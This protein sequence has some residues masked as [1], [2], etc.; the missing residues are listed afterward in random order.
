M[1]RGENKELVKIHGRLHEGQATM[2]NI[3][4]LP[5]QSVI[6]AFSPKYNKKN[7]SLLKSGI[8]AIIISKLNKIV[9]IFHTRAKIW[10]STFHYENCL[11]Y[12]ILFQLKLIL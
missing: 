6:H 11:L 8:K 12:W 5:W 4:N 2:T 7:N 9:A 10:V 1:N 3:N